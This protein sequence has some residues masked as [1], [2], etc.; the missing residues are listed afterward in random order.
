M[1]HM[2]MSISLTYPLMVMTR[3]LLYYNIMLL[4]GN[5]EKEGLARDKDEGKYHKA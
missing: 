2:N 3:V 4:N 1:L 5:I